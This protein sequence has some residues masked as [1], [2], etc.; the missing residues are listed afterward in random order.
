MMKATGRLLHVKR[1]VSFFMVLSTLIGV[2]LSFGIDS[3][4]ALPTGKAAMIG[5]DANTN[6]IKGYF[7]GRRDLNN[8]EYATLGSKSEGVY[9]EKEPGTISYYKIRSANPIFKDYNYFT[10]SNRGY[11]YLSKKSDAAS[12]MISEQETGLSNVYH[13]GSPVNTYGDYITVGKATG[14][15]KT[16]WLFMS[17]T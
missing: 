13:N 1:L 7:T 14:S 3:Y 12:F 4:A 9:L 15:D 8:W 16:I 2:S 5:G 11:I 6:K 17:Q 10:V